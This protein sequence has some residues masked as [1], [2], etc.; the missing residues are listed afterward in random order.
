MSSAG[1]KRRLVVVMVGL[2]V[3]LGGLAGQPAGAQDARGD[4]GRRCNDCYYDE[5]PSG[6]C[7]RQRQGCSDC[8]YR[9]RPCD[10][11]DRPPPCRRCDTGSCGDRPDGRPSCGDRQ[12]PPPCRDCYYDTPPR[13]SDAPR[14]CYDDDRR[15]CGERGRRPPA[16]NCEENARRDRCDD[17]TD[18]D[19]YDGRRGDRRGGR[20]RDD[21]GSGLERLL[22][23]IFT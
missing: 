14:N 16:R 11:R 7:G 17:T 4:R 20:D 6:E 3:G 19:D 12:S 8:Y 5:R 23:R 22:R 1:W 13:D 2:V 9:D 21:E 15:P 18:R 10:G